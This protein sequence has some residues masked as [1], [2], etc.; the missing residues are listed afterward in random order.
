MIIW[1]IPCDV[2]TGSD[3][4]VDSMLRLQ[5]KRK[6]KKRCFWL[7]LLKH[8]S[9]RKEPDSIFIAL[10]VVDHLDAHKKSQI[11]FQIKIYNLIHTMSLMNPSEMYMYKNWGRIGRGVHLW[12]S[13]KGWLY[14]AVVLWSQ[15]IASSIEARHKALYGQQPGNP[16]TFWTAHMI[17]TSERFSVWVRPASPPAPPPPARFAA[18]H[19]HTEKRFWCTYHLLLSIKYLDL[20]ASRKLLSSLGYIG[21]Y[22]VNYNS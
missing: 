3:T 2:G 6:S 9:S 7:V 20:A 12:L 4:W 21:L 8:D 13:R 5:T 14:Y 1:W 16:G 22:W 11:N 19:T 10:S 18:G 17:R 15:T